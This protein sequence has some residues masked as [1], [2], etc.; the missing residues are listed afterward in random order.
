[1]SK[2]PISEESPPS[3]API[4]QKILAA[5]AWIARLLSVLRR[6]G[7]SPED[8]EDLIQ[9]AFVRLTEYSRT[10]TVRNEAAFLKR[11]VTNLAIDRY[12]YEASHPCTEQSVEELADTPLLTDPSPSPDEVF[13]AQQRL[14][15]VR[16][17]LDRVSVRTRQ[18][19]FA[20]RAGYSHRELADAFGVSISTIEKAIARAV[21]A[22]MDLAMP[23][24]SPIVGDGPSAARQLGKT[25]R[26]HNP[27]L[28]GRRDR[29]L[30]VG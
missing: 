22:L 21:V 29:R 10:T 18:I 7:R 28:P 17:A 11:T 20:H 30:S 6:Q 26:R 27:P 25:G 15:E 13:A 24:E 23:S 14:D 5:P 3:A 1:M 19:F 2:R 9:E 8:S 12:R 4:V 16:R